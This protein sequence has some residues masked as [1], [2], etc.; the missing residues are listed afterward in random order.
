MRSGPQIASQRAPATQ[1]GHTGRCQAIGFTP[2]D[3]R[4]P[5]HQLIE[6][7]DFAAGK[8]IRP[9]CRRGDFAAQPKPID[10]VVDVR[11]VIVNLTGTENHETATGDAAKEFQEAPIAWP[12]DASRTR[13]DNFDAGVGRCLACDALAFELRLL[14]DVARTERRILVGRRM[15]DIAVH[16]DSA[17]VDHAPDAIRRPRRESASSRSRR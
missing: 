2:A 4:N 11:Q 12:V 15:L 13:D 9:P 10:E 7:R 8:N 5:R 3:C 16:A 6:R 1:N 14:V 17:A